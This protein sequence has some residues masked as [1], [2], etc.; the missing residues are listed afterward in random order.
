MSDEFTNFRFLV[1]LD[2]A[3]AYIPPAQ[4]ALLLGFVG[5]A[6][7]EVKGLGADLEVTAYPEGGT[8]DFVHQLPVR[9]S[10]TRLSFRRGLVREPGLWW[11][12]WAGL[13]QSLG[14]RRDGAILLLGEDGMPTMTWTFRA[15]IAVKWTGPEFS[16]MQGAIAIEGIEIAHHGLQQI[17]V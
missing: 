12:Y 5:G 8:G 9:H 11:W 13:S 15:G 4:A 1:T 16:A 17:L 14:A 2:P 7:Q 3:D 6:F 10:W